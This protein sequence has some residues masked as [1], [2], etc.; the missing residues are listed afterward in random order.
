MGRAFPVFTGS[1]QRHNY[2]RKENLGYNSMAMLNVLNNPIL[3]L[4]LGSWVGSMSRILKG[5]VREVSLVQVSCI[6]MYVY[7]GPPTPVGAFAAR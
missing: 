2:E 1:S 5:C 4:Q 3:T 6:P 7:V